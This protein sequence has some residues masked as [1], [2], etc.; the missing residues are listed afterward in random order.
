LKVRLPA[1]PETPLHEGSKPATAS[2]GGAP[3]DG[4]SGSV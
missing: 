2:G 4:G 1:E 3:C